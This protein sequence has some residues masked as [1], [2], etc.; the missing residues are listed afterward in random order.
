VLEQAPLSRLLFYALTQGEHADPA[1]AILLPVIADLSALEA[2]LGAYEVAG[3]VP[4]LR[5]LARALAG[6][7]RR[8]QVVAE[9]RGRQIRTN[10]PRRSSRGT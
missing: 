9:V 1:L 5:Q 10:K 4:S 6:V 7:R 8:V 2:H 3:H